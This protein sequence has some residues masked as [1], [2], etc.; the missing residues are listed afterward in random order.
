MIVK[1]WPKQYSA[2]AF[3][4]ANRHPI[5][6]KECF[7]HGVDVPMPV[8]TPLIAGADGMIVAKGNQTGLGFTLEIKYNNGMHGIYHHLKNHSKF[9]VGDSVR[10][11][12]VVAH[13]GN[14]GRTTGSHLHF[15]LHKISNTRKS[16]DPLKHIIRRV[17]K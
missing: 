1:P 14:S 9:D 11:T 4:G 6:G 16:V 13:S 8:G 5:L 10:S 2:T 7:H 17:I 15:E 12:D 3:W